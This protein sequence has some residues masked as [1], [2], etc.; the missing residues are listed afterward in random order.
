MR[1]YANTGS[2]DPADGAR[3]ADGDHGLMHRR[4]AQEGRPRISRLD[5]E[6]IRDHVELE[7]REALY[8]RR[9]ASVHR[10]NVTS[11]GVHRAGDQERLQL[12]R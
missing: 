11:H 8:G 4:R 2:V 3:L 1:S 9:M 7:V 5:Q 10:V 6:Q 12:V